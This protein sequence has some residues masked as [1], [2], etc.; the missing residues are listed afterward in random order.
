MCAKDRAE[1][2]EY[3]LVRIANQS[4]RFAAVKLRPK[5]NSES[6]MRQRYPI[7]FRVE[8]SENRVA[9]EKRKTWRCGP[10]ALKRSCVDVIDIERITDIRTDI[11]ADADTDSSCRTWRV[12]YFL[13]QKHKTQTFEMRNKRARDE[14]VRKLKYLCRL[15]KLRKG[16]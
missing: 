13:K 7:V 3:E 5:S 15:A 10:F 8:P 14:I 9:L 1:A 16:K 11:G 2:F 12:S 6:R 4:A